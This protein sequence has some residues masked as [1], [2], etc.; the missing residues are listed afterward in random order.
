MRWDGLTVLESGW[1]LI[2]VGGIYCAKLGGNYDRR[3]EAVIRYSSSL[4][5]EYTCMRIGSLNKMVKRPALVETPPQGVGDVLQDWLKQCST[6]ISC[7]HIMCDA[8]A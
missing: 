8:K 4:L 5:E 7:C 2:D 1:K 6:Q 3:D